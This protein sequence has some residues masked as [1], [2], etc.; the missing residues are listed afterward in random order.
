MWFFNPDRRAT[1]ELTRRCDSSM[2]DL[3][4]ASRDNADRANY[5]V[6][7]FSRQRDTWERKLL[8]PGR[9]YSALPLTLRGETPP[10]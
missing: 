1:I 6:L 2:H 8:S 9:I 5:I 4:I 10:R 3:N 7:L